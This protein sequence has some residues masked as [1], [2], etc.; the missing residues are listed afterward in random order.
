MKNKNTLLWPLIC[1]PVLGAVGA[2]LR[3]WLFS[4]GVDEKGLI[5]TEHPAQLLIWLLTLAV[6]VTLV[7]ATRWIKNSA[8]YRSNFPPSVLGSAGF[9]L[10]AGATAF[11][12]L[13]RLD[14]LTDILSIAGFALGCASILCLAFLAWKRFYGQRPNP[15][16]FII[17][18]AWLMVDLILLYRHWSATPQVQNY[19]FSLLANVCIMLSVYYSATFSA[20]MGNRQMHTLFHL[21]AVFFCLVSLPKC[22]NSVY[23]GLMCGFMMLDIRPLEIKPKEG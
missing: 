14:T 4:T 7:I 12:T 11:V 19:C 23:Y 3:Y 20:N 17:I 5:V 10:A 13:R 2:A 21:L 6:S 16:A 8:D 9:L 18:C 1:V 15:I 22:E